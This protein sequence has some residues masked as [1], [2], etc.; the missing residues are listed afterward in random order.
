MTTLFLDLETY[1]EEPITHGTHRYAE[2]AE[3]LLV[4]WAFDSEPVTVWDMTDGTRTLDQVQM[5]IDS[6]DCVV[7]HNSAFDRTVLRHRG[8]HI[9]VERIDDTMVMALLHSLPGSLDALCGVLDV[10]QD[11][12]KSKSGKRLIQ[13]FTKPRPKNIKLRRATRESHPDEWQEFIEYARLDVGAM[14]CVHERLPRWNHTRGERALWQLDQT[15]NDRGI[16]VDLELARS[17]VR[18][19]QRTSGSLAASAAALTGGAV[20]SLTQR[21]KLMDYLAV[22]HGFT[23][24]DLTKGT[25]TALLKRDD[26]DPEVRSLLEIRQQASATSPAKYKVLLNAASSDGR[27]RGTIQFCGASRTARSAGRLVQVQNLPRPLLKQDAI[28]HGIAAMKA[29]C[30]DLVVDNVS[31]LCSSAVRGCF[32]AAEGCKLV[33][34]DLSN[35]EGRVA[36]WLAGEDWKVEAFKAFDAK[37]GPDLY[38]LAYAKSFGKQPD[39]VTKDER[40][41]GKVQEL[42][43]GFGGGV[44]AFAKMAEI[45]GIQLP[46]EQVAQIVKAWRRA[47]PAI[48]SFW[49]ALEQA[50][51]DAIR[52]PDEAFP[53]RELVLDMKAGYLRIR[54]PSGRFLSYKG[55]HIEDGELRYYG[56]NQ[57]TRKW[58]AIS[59]YGGK[60][61]EN[62]VQAIARDVFMGGLAKAEA[63]AYRVVMQVHDELVC[64]VPD[65]EDHTVAGLV[66]CMTHG[67]SWSVGLPLAA[68]G[69]EMHRYA[70]LD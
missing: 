61:F 19:F 36:A 53:V 63:A 30:E 48:S 66:A 44:G 70:K 24:A 33:V 35:I 59:T 21:Q 69:H 25:V 39:D 31:E 42:A 14:R 9:P 67:E 43:L 20:G 46:E 68:A 3:V 34:A 27:M 5:L 7:I 40:Q 8:V 62:I 17:A 23:P 50:A 51:R 11:H 58:E 29:D 65:T 55:A 54:L 37:I 38:K 1:A 22:K 28:E 52:N 32:I 26:L 41:V 49:Y 6:A 18:A 16:C 56:V 60:L 64:E 13:L 15:I 45:Y 10:P 47:H 57:Y 2:S 4:A 12:A